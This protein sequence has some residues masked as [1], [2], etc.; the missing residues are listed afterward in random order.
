M[1]AVVA[2]GLPFQGEAGK[3]DGIVAFGPG[4]FRFGASR[5]VGQE[6]LIANAVEQ[7]KTMSGRP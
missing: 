3:D 7:A 6:E 2:F 1:F 4:G 5:Q